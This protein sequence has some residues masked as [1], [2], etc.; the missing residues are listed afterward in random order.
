M[1]P[2][3]TQSIEQAIQE[4]FENMAFLETVPAQEDGLKLPADVMAASLTITAPAPGVVHMVLPTTLLRN[5]GETL[6]AAPGEELSQEVLQDLLFELLNTIVG[7]LLNKFLPEDQSY[8]LGLPE[9]ENPVL[10]RPGD[11]S[12]FLVDN[13]PVLASVEGKI[14][15]WNAP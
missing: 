12:W 13:H 3:L 4:T 7:M 11:R 5:M 14:L 9:K 1:N 10:P 2:K 6:H 15:S 8:N